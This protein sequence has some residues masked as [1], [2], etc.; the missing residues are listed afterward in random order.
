MTALGVDVTT[1]D[2]TFG[3]EVLRPSAINMPDYVIDAIREFEAAEEK[4]NRLDKAMD[5]ALDRFERT[6][7]EEDQEKFEDAMQS[8]KFFFPTYQRAEDKLAYAKKFWYQTRNGVPVSISKT[9]KVE[10][11][12]EALQDHEDDEVTQ[13][14]EEAAQTIWDREEYED[15][16]RDPRL[17]NLPY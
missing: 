11:L 5:V 7:K 14:M 2:P 1:N 16:E 3:W 17:E 15:Y 4:Y 12:T 6:G 8:F 9:L 10:V 13:E